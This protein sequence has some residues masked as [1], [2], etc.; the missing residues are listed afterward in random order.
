MY[1]LVD[2]FEYYDPKKN[3]S[4]EHPQNQLV[5]SHL[6]EIAHILLDRHYDGRSLRFTDLMKTVSA[7]TGQKYVFYPSCA[8]IMELNE[9]FYNQTGHLIAA[10]LL[11]DKPGL[12]SGPLFENAVELG[13]LDIEATPEE[14]EEF[15]VGEG[16]FFKDMC[17]RRILGML[18]DIFG[19]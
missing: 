5:L 4:R 8:A 2:L 6:R 16:E 1:K 19:E 9:L 14:Q 17:W 12:L 7:M 15:W 13:A 18:E 11:F 10:C 3:Y